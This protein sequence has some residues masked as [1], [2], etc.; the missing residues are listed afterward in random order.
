MLQ[1]D[2]PEDYVIATGR[3]ETVRRFIEIT[4]NFLGWNKDNENGFI[5]ENEGINEVDLRADNKE[6]VVRIDSRYFRPTEVKQLL[7]DSKKS[8]DKLGWESK[9]SLEEIISEMV[10]FDKKEG[11]KES[12]LKGKGFKIR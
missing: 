11:L 5:Q 1:Q 7:A 10:N 4:S 12:I 8:R 6:I 2:Q 3:M 9:T